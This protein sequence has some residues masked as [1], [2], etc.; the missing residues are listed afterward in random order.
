MAGTVTEVLE[1]PLYIPTCKVKKKI[2]WEDE[3][4]KTTPSSVKEEE[5]NSQINRN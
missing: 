2:S 5:L 4:S 3:S 1:A